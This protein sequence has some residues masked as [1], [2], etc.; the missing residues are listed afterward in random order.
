MWLHLNLDIM[1]K[2]REEKTNF[3]NDGK[4]ITDMLFNTKLFK[5]D[6]TRDDIKKVEIFIGECMSL[7]FE[8]YKK[9]E[10]LFSSIEKIKSSNEL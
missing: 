4:M 7:R 3:R 10:K 6:I 8:T 2:E 9:A 5:E 1:E